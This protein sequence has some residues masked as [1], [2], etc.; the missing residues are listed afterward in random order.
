MKESKNKLIAILIIFL[1][2]FPIVIRSAPGKV[3]LVLGSDTATWDGMDV[4]KYSPY[5][6][7]E[8]YL[9]PTQNC[10]KVMS[11][12]F[13]NKLRDSYGNT[14]KLTWWMMGGDIFRYAT[15]KNM[16]IPNTMTINLMQ[17]YHGNSIAQFG[18][19][20]SIHYHTFFWSDYD[21]DGKY[22]W[23]QSKKFM[24][25]YDDFNFTLGQY[26]LEENI[27]PVSFRSGWHY[28]D[29]GWQNYL[30]KL[31]PYSLHNDYPVHGRDT[32]EPIDN[33][34]DWS[35]SSPLWVPFHPSKSNYQLAGACKGY[36]VRSK[37]IGSV[38]KEIMDTMFARAA[39]GIDQV[40]CLWGHLP[41]TDFLTN[42]QKIDSLTHLSATKY[43]TVK[44]KYATAVEGMQEWR[45]C[46]DKLKPEINFKEIQ[47]G[48]NIKFSVT[49]NKALFQETPFLCAKD[50]S[51][52]YFLMPMHS[53]GNNAWESNNSYRKDLLAKVAVAVTDTSGNL[54]T[55]FIKYLPDDIFIDNKSSKCEY[56]TGVW[57][58]ETKYHYY[59]DGTAHSTTSDSAEFRIKIKAPQSKIYNLFLQIPQSNNPAN[60]TNIY[61]NDGVKNIDSMFFK[62]PLKMQDWV[63]LK[64]INFDSNK[65]YTIKLSSFKD[66]KGR[67][68]AFDALKITALVPDRKIVLGSNYLYFKD[69][70]QA[71]SSIFMLDIQNA[72]Q[73]SLNISKITSSLSNLSIRSKFPITIEPMQKVSIPLVFTGD[74]IGTFADSLKISSDDS[75]NPIVNVG[76]SVSCTRYNK[77]VDNEDVQNYSEGGGVWQ[78]SVAVS[79]GIT[80][81]ICYSNYKG[82]WAEFNT[83]LLQNGTY[84]VSYI[85]PLTTNALD[86]VIY[87]LK[88]NNKKVDSVYANQNTNSNTWV[89][90]FRFNAQANI[91]VGVRV[92]N[93]GSFKNG[94]VLRTDAVKFALS[95]NQVSN[96]KDCGMNPYIFDLS[97]NYPN[98]FNPSTIINYSVS[99]P[100]YVEMN[101]YNMIGQRIC[102]LVSENQP[103]G[104]YKITFDAGKYNLSSGIYFYKLRA[105][106]FEMTKKMILIK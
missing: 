2:I 84:D 22:Y 68:F 74:K 57:N 44:F 56:S 72:G 73:K 59:F 52:N 30:D 91:P 51:E 88:V 94:A 5:Y 63:Y 12:N 8:L 47:N 31:L 101:I 98:P 15:N 21:K 99:L 61:I 20:L 64:T 27:F 60:I 25:C 89:K 82:A 69:F 24:D 93:D 11:P 23:N 85:V 1:L 102:C 105:G 97:Q 42:L 49:S 41:E 100:S 18:D 70:C 32:I 39:R 58:E 76:Y 3:I 87:Y 86:K 28:M 48:S 50:I 66:T 75:V 90:V 96:T 37:H 54:T 103:I 106:N 71:D 9:D 104:N 77:V 36:N 29:N 92:V 80:S 19:E 14:M 40:A 6:G 45:K 43:S 26:L 65:T 46:S 83:K 95:E 78:N 10:Y 4:T 35:K 13:R 67:F 33:D 7:V 34:Y 79:N 55:S 38:T 81:R 17:K 62:T 53:V 16:P